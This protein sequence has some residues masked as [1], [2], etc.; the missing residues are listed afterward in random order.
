MF[1]YPSLATLH[2]GRTLWEGGDDVSGQSA[3][4]LQIQRPKT[5][6]KLGPGFY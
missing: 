6:M 1:V 5:L 2:V 3:Q 4:S